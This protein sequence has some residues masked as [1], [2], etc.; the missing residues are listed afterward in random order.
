M[1]YTSL[2][3]HSFDLYSFIAYTNADL[4]MINI[5]PV[6]TKFSQNTIIFYKETYLKMLHNSNI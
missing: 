6:R 1:H 2:N 4:F 3:I 5:K